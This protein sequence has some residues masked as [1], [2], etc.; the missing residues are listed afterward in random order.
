[1]RAEKLRQIQQQQQQQQQ[2]FS[3]AHGKV[4]HARPK[5]PT[6]L[7]YAHEIDKKAKCSL[8]VKMQ[9]H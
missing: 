3:H 9:E 5:E 4:A 2:Q 8:L 7:V 1:M 6:E